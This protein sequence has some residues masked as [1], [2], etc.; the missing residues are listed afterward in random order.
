VFKPALEAYYQVFPETDA[1][2][3]PQVQLRA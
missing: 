3:A 1:V 2:I